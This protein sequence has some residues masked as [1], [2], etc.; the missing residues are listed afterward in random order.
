[1]VL[2]R[3]GS[4][5]LLL[6]FL[7]PELLLF[8]PIFLLFF[9]SQFRLLC[10]AGSLEA[11][12]RKKNQLGTHLDRGGK[13]GRENGVQGHSHPSSVN[14]RLGFEQKTKGKNHATSE[15]SAVIF[16][17]KRFLTKRHE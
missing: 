11:F 14:V 10:C 5:W 9:S 13:G 6:V 8:P 1:M 15:R 17:M 16:I 7:S 12:Y 4:L 3:I 2:H